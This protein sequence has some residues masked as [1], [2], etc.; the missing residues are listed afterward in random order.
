MQHLADP[1]LLSE[2]AA[3]DEFAADFGAILD[4]PDAAEAAP[5]LPSE[6][7]DFADDLR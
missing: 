1:R 3:P 2:P 6:L 7:P 5:G 4:F